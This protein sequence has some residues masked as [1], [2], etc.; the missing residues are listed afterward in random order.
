MNLTLKDM[1]EIVDYICEVENVPTGPVVIS[2]RMTKTYAVARHGPCFYP[3]DIRISKY[4][5]YE[6]PMSDALATSIIIHE[7]CHWVADYRTQRRNVHND[8][9]MTY[10]KKWH[11]EFGLHE[12]RTSR[13]RH[14]EMFYVSADKQLI[15]V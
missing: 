7:I 11:E 5:F 4:W 14:G 3:K 15:P 2:S 8:L 9:F 10:S 13:I 6:R 1:Q 12:K